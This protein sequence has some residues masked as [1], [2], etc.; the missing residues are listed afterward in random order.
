MPIY[1]NVSNL[2]ALHFRDI[3]SMRVSKGVTVVLYSNNSWQGTEISIDNDVTYVGH[4][5][6][7]AKSCQV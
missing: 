4:K 5:V 2:R 7:H 1:E 6:S 3:S